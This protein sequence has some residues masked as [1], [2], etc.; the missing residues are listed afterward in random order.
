MF[1]TG[2]LVASSTMILAGTQLILI[3]AAARTFATKL[4]L[5]PRTRSFQ[6]W[7]ERISLERGVVAGALAF[8]IG[9]VGV[10]FAVV[11]WRHAGFG[12]LDPDRN[13]RLLVPSMT[14]VVLGLQLMFGS[15]L[16]GIA[17]IKTV[18]ES[19]PVFV[20]DDAASLSVGVDAR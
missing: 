4:G 16:L 20:E 11:R 12:E 2:T 18:R 9:A 10:V 13:I 19:V 17:T 1:D 5:L 14:G 6:K 3:W 8:V 7:V 15:F